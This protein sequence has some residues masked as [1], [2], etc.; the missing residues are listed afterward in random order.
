M[1]A[2]VLGDQT[3]TEDIVEERKENVQSA[4]L[5]FK[6]DKPVGIQ[7]HFNFPMGDRRFGEMVANI[8]SLPDRYWIPER[9]YWRIGLSLETGRKLKEWEFR[10]SED[11]QK[12]FDDLTKP[13]DKNI[14]DISRLDPRLFP[15]EKEGVIFIESRKGRALNGD[16]MGLGKSC[17]AISWLRLHPPFRPAIIVCPATIKIQ[18]KQEL[19]KWGLGKEK[20][21]I[22]LGK[23]NDYI[24][25]DQIIIIN[26]D[27]LTT[28]LDS[29][30]A[31]NPK[32][33]IL[34]EIHY[35]KS[36]KAQRTKAAKWLAKRIPYVIGLSGTPIINRPIEFFNAINMIR[37]DIFPNFWSFAREFCGARWTGFGWD[38]KG[39]TNTDKLHKLLTETIMIRR[40]KK[41]VLKDLPDK[42]YSI[43]PFEIVNREE[44]DRAA[45]NIVDWIFEHEGEEK[46]DRASQAEVLV[47]FEKLKQLAVM[48]KIE[49]VK[50]WIAD[51]LE[52]GEKLVLFA[53]HI[54]T[55]DIL[56]RAFPKISVR[57]D[58]STSQKDRQET[59]DRFQNDDRT[60]LFLGNIKAAGIG[61]T[62]TSA[63]NVGFVELPWTPGDY[64]QASDRLHRIGQKNAVNVWTLVAQDTV[65]EDIALILSNKAKVLSAVLDGKNVDD[66]SLLSGLIKKV[67]EKR[68]KDL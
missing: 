36:S 14:I 28:W 27:I 48:G 12:W 42:I 49:S 37:P 65:E 1:L 22:I 32:V 47:E 33:L 6:D 13:V 61:I 45:S 54:S 25:M 5:L 20:I 2:G 9:K 50:E 62:L 7:V 43:V 57:L 8:K 51:F 63:S 26:Y 52:S 40:L 21:H 24:L 46:A 38:F 53:T 29:L 44:Y 19:E 41:D 67:K 31:I 59:V 60:R 64:E 16:E 4:S 39:A 58:G 3:G 35:T 66:D 30:E 17:Q 34:D 55:L 23:R 18:W 56:Q 10:F 68:E 11:L 15:F